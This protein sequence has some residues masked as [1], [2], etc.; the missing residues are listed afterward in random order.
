MTCSEVKDV[1]DATVARFVPTPNNGSPELIVI[2]KRSGSWQIWCY[3]QK[4]KYVW[5]DNKKTFRGLEF[6]TN[7]SYTYYLNWKG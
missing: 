6:P 7:Q 4:L 5:D 3:F 1:N 2:K